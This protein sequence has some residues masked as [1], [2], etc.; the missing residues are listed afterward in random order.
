MSRRAAS[1][2]VAGNDRGDVLA[3]GNDDGDGR[4][5]LALLALGRGRLLAAA[6][7]EH[8]GQDGQQHDG[9]DD[10]DDVAA[11]TATSERLL[12]DD[13]VVDRLTAPFRRFE[14]HRFHLPHSA[15]R[16]AAASLS[17]CII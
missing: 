8:H 16:L 11:A 13:D 12:V 14:V 10:E 15:T 7:H 5:L 17:R 1:D 6:A 9:G 3:A 4:K 2:P